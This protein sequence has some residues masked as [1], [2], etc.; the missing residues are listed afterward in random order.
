M[1]EA[2]DIG[3]SGLQ[4]QR[5][6]MDAIAG[7]ILNVNTTRNERGEKVP[8]R[9]RFVVLAPGE[10]GDASKP[11]V[12]VQEIGL[13]PSPPLKKYEPGH[14]DADADGY[15][16]YPN[17]DTTIEYVNAM[18]A[19]RAYEANVTMMEV[20]KAMISSSLRIIA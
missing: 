13:D 19:S 11:G 18:E 10:A 7:N 8:Y 2:L 15:V 6:R 14:P 3:A 4:A 5:T 20:S 17:I 16:S 12:H 1:F 9:R